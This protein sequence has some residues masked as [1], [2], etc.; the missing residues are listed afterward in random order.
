MIKTWADY[1]G[2]ILL[3]WSDRGNK[4]CE[5]LVLEYQAR[6]GL[7]V[8]EISDEDFGRYRCISERAVDRTYHHKHWKCCACSGDDVDPT[9]AARAEATRQKFLA[10]RD[11][12]TTF[13]FYAAQSVRDYANPKERPSKTTIRCGQCVHLQKRDDHATSALYQCAI[14][15]PAGTIGPALPQLRALDPG[16]APITCPG[17]ALRQKETA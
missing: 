3:G 6:S 5:F 4:A 13:D 8:V 2:H 14:R 12:M 7:F 1:V 15:P 16:D 10:D 17:A 9:L 11:N